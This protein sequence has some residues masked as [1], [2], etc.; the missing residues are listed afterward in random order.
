MRRHDAY[1]T[2]LCEAYPDFGGPSLRTGPI[3]KLH[4]TQFWVQFCFG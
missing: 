1:L 3:E 2:A 4:A